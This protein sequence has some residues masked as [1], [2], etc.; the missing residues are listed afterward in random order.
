MSIILFS[1]NSLRLSNGVN[2]PYIGLGTGGKRSTPEELE[3]AIRHAIDIGYRHID[4]ASMYE[5]EQ[6][7]GTTLAELIDSGKVTRKELFITTKLPPSSNRPELVE[8]TLRAQ[9]KDLKMDYV[10]LYLIHS[11]TS[12]VPSTEGYKMYSDS[13][14]PRKCDHVDLARTW[15]AME[16]IYEKGL[17]RAIGLSNFNV[18]QLQYIYHAAKV[19]PHNLQIEVHVHFPQRELH[20]L[21]TSLNISVTA[22]APLGCPSKRG[23]NGWPQEVAVDDPTVVKL[24]QK[25]GKTPAQILLRHLIQRQIVVIPKSTKSTRLRENFSIFDFEITSEDMIE[26]NSIEPRRR[27]YTWIGSGFA[28]IYC[29]A[30]TL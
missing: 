11:P 1:M 12:T 29:C 30:C 8:P 28:F 26:L 17:A 23:V 20:T 2:I 3:D 4:T 21:C 22:Y 13:N 24:A 25:Y 19:K 14:V 27:L 16:K 7:I 10:D 9:L 15:Q 6:I 5:N 18:E